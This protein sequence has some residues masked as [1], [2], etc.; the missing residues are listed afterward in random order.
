M[1]ERILND[2]ELYMQIKK[3]QQ[4]RLRDFKYDS[5]YMLLKKYI[6]EFAEG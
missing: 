5:T 2:N 6:T 1:A 4:E 3:N